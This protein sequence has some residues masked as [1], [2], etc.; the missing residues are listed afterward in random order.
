MENRGYGRDKRLCFYDDAVWHEAIVKL[1]RSHQISI[2]ELL[3]HWV[4]LGNYILDYPQPTSTHWT[5]HQ[6]GP[7]T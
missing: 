1:A 7:R 4:T 5:S 3:L 2:S 6:R